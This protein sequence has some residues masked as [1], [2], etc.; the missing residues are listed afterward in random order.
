MDSDY[1]W[2]VN[3]KSSFWYR[4][5]N[6]AKKKFIVCGLRLPL[7][8]KL[9]IIILASG[10]KSSKKKK[11][12]IVCGALLVGGG[13]LQIIILASVTKSSKKYFL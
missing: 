1:H 11:N 2:G 5:Q 3:Y 10:T 6:P 7:G 12:F 4:E 9:Q 8:G 13:K